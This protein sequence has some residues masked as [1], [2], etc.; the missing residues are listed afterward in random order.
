MVYVEGLIVKKKWQSAVS[1]QRSV[2]RKKIAFYMDVFYNIH[3][4]LNLHRKTVS[5]SPHGKPSKP[6]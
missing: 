3:Y 5:I 1:R 2:I 6:F 4:H